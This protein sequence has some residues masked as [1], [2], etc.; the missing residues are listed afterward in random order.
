[1]HLDPGVPGARALAVLGVLAALAAAFFLW[2]SRPEPQPLQGRALPGVRPGRSA[3]PPAG[4]Q[5]PASSSAPPA[6]LIVQVIGKVAHPGVFTLPTGSRVG[7]AITAAGGL[8]A[9]AS[10]GAL[11]LARRLTDG[12]QVP[13]GVPGAPPVVAQPGSPTGSDGGTAQPLDLNSATADQL[14]QLPGVGPVYAKRILDYRTQH[15]GFRS[16]DELRQ[17]SGIGQHRFA[18]IKPLVHI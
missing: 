8:A 17:I 15:G 5:P 16:I 7:D 1:V 6:S 14:Q 13:V 18:Q 10:T 9:G 2:L 11:N 4:S 12:E 3:S